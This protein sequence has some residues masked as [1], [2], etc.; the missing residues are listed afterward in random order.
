M[1]DSTNG[2]GDGGRPGPGPAPGAGPKPAAG[3]AWH[4]RAWGA[5]R[6]TVRGARD[7]VRANLGRLLTFVVGVLVGVLLSTLAANGWPFVGEEEGDTGGDVLKVL[8]SFDESPRGERERL[9]KTWNALHPDMKADIVPVSSSADEAASDM[10]TAAQSTAYDVDVYNLDV[11]L[12]GRVRRERLDPPAGGRRHHRVPREAAR[13]LPL[14]GQAVGAAVQ[15]RRRPALL[16]AAAA[17]RARHLAGARRPA[18]QPAPLVEHDRD[19]DRHRGLRPAG[20]RRPAPR[21]LHR[22]VRR[23]R[24]PH[25][26]RDGGDLGR[27]GRGG[28][29]RGQGPARLR[30]RAP[31]PAGPRR[32]LPVAARRAAGLRRVPRGREQ[33]R[34]R[35]AIACCS[36]ATGRWRTGSSPCRTTRPP[37]PARRSPRRPTSP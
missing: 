17:R 1:V 33:G 23:L 13:H 21:R 24:G 28:R 9:I 30:G 18:R 5:V 16:P 35:P 31:G 15:H 20:A 6:R 4:R 32:R 11:I 10:R 34:V 27:G 2:A 12:D 7:L 3:A 22:P 26:Q 8:S 36:C 14:R 19:A 25:G 29:R 37:A